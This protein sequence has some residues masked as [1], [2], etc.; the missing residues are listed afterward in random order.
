MPAILRALLVL[1][2]FSMGW[3]GATPSKFPRI[4]LKL[5]SEGNCGGLENLTA[6]EIDALPTIDEL[7][8]NGKAKKVREGP[9]DISIE[10]SSQIILCCAARHFFLL[11]FL[12]FDACGETFPCCRL[13]VE[14]VFKGAEVSSRFHYSTR[15]LNGEFSPKGVAPEDDTEARGE[16]SIEAALVS[17]PATCTV[18]AVGKSSDGFQ[19][20]ELR[21]RVELLSGG[22]VG[23]ETADR[24]GGKYLS[25]K[26]TYMAA[27]PAMA[28]R[29]REELRAFPGAMMVF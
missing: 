1:L 21:D 8:A 7:L 12:L 9:E 29:V 22:A 25:V 6:A 27:C 23:V 26:L 20:K 2:P 14:E 5:G 11:I 15:A 17:F 4:L 24:S 13:Q 18:T 28:R 10:G 16:G 19:Q 3:M